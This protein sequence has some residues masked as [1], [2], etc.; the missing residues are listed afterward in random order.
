MG[1]V[2]WIVRNLFS[3]PMTNR[4]PK[5]PPVPVPEGFRG[6]LQYDPEK[7][8]GCQLCVRVC[9]TQTIKFLP[10]EKKIAFWVGRCVFCSQCVEVCPTGALQMS[11]NFLLASD[12]MHDERYMGGPARRRG[13]ER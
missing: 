8:I 5:T 10:E 2:S 12:D 6:K 3:R 1:L 11:K 7:C 9:P 4:F 13:I